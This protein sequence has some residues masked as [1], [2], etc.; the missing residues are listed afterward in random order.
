M[1]HL[2]TRGAESCSIL[3]L[4]AR[5]QLLSLAQKLHVPKFKVQN[6]RASVLK[7]LVM[8]IAKLKVNHFHC[9][10]HYR[11][12][13]HVRLETKTYTRIH[14][15]KHGKAAK[16]VAYIGMWPCHSVCTLADMQDAGIHVLRTVCH[17][18]NKRKPRTTVKRSQKQSL[19]VIFSCMGEHAP[20]RC[21]VPQNLLS[22]KPEPSYFCRSFSAP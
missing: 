15:H 4:A 8:C 9:S 13:L 20:R 3:D 16:N 14:T 18:H 17:H 1:V 21:Q 6:A 5:S 12:Q 11:L 19:G 7:P 10:R 2:N 22:L